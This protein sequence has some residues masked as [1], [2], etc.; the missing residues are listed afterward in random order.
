MDSNIFLLIIFFAVLGLILFISDRNKKKRVKA[1]LAKR[2]HD[3]A[4]T[5]RYVEDFQR[6]GEEMQKNGIPEIESDIS[7]KKNETLHVKLAGTKWMEYRKLRTGR[8]SGHVVSARVKIVKGLSYRYS[9]GQMQSESLDQ[10]TQ[11][12]TG[13]FY[14]TNKTLF[15]RGSMG[16]KSLPLEKIVQLVPFESGLKIEKETGKDIYIPFNFRQ[17]PDKAAAI[18]LLWDKCRNS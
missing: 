11:I 10:L 16:N 12:D 8:V 2:D 7:L 13:D 18:A 6:V 3:D 17:S 15:F 4:I 5:K 14:I 9:V 1:V